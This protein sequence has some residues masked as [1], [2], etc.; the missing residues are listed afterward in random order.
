MKN[1][2]LLIA[3]TTSMLC[4]TLLS[5]C[6]GN[7]VRDDAQSLQIFCVDAGYRTQWVSDIKDLFV[8][9]DWVKQKYPNLNVRIDTSKDQ[10]YGRTRMDAGRSSNTIDLFFDMGLTNYNGSDD[11]LDLTETVY[12]SSVPG[13]DT[14]F[15]N[16]IDASYLEAFTFDGQSDP[17]KKGHQFFAPWAGGMTGILYNADIFSSLNYTVPNTTDELV[18]LC[19]DYQGRG[20]ETSPKYCFIQGNDE[21]YF[22]YLFD[23]FWTQYQAREGYLDF[24]NGIADNVV[25]KD[26]F[27][28]QG[29]MEALLV[30]ESLVKNEKHFVNPNSINQGFAVAQ[31][32]FLKGEALFNVNG[33][34]FVSETKDIKGKITNPASI[35]MMKTPIISA[36]KN[37]VPDS[38]I[39]D[40]A[41]LSALVKAIDSHDTS[42]SGAGY[43]VT[44][45]DYDYVKAARA[46]TYSIGA[47]HHAAIPSYA[48]AKGLAA[49][50]IRYLA[51]DKAIE[52]YIKATDG[53]SMPFAYDLETKNPAL[54]A[55]IDPIHQSRVQYFADTFIDPYTLPNK[56]MFPLIKYGGV[57]TFKLANGYDFFVQ[58]GKKNG[59]K[60]PQ[61]YW[62][63]TI[64]YWTDDKWQ[65]AC[66]RAGI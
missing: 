16:K 62:D 13:E 50:F 39:G 46:I 21:T 59:A 27:K 63:E 57:D 38:S 19:A 20:T 47:G 55:K 17:A 36:I 6:G 58:M 12:N 48:T 60:T 32:M 10:T 45:A 28:Q 49:D 64:S 5:A 29:R 15:K 9:E 2:R 41:E 40:D 54:F 30:Y 7:K 31:A 26:I 3:M 66:E 4:A 24:V 43:E 33:D 51:T 1:N 8:Q 37:V 52:A 42:L 23:I 61:Q 53:A 18:A 11:L 14:L 34:W 56:Y 35:K 44:Q 25:S 65:D 22:N